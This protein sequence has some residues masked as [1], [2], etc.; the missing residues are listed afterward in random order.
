MIHMVTPTGGGHFQ[1]WCPMTDIL[2]L[3]ALGP[4][5]A[6]LGPSNAG[7][8]RLAVALG[9][10]LGAPVVHLDLL[11]HLPH[12][13]WVPRPPADFVRLHSEAIAART[14][15]MEGNYMGLFAERASR[16][17]GLVMLGSGPWPALGRYVRR[18]LFER[19]RAG[20]LEGGTDRLNLDMVRFILV[21]QPRKRERDL[22]L[23]RNSG[24]PLVVLASM[25]DLR[26][27]YRDWAL[28]PA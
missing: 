5:I 26:R 10:K 12:T 2:P 20:M 7:K 9:A 13:N 17:T 18:T 21:E 28:P 23:A 6:I 24:L 1:L 16:A 22:D 8:S 15:V 3:E 19:R 14:W 27:A 4:R 25:R 11:H